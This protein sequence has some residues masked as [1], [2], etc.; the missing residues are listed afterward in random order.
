MDRETLLNQTYRSLTEQASGWAGTTSVLR[1]SLRGVLERAQQNIIASVDESTSGISQQFVE[2]L[3]NQLSDVSQGWVDDATG[4][5]CPVPDGTKFFSREGNTTNIIVEQKPQQRRIRFLDS[6]FL[7]SL[8]YIQFMTVFV[9]NGRSDVFSS[10]KVSCSKVPFSSMDQNVHVLPL[11]NIGYG[12]PWK[13]CT[14]RVDGMNTGG[15]GS[16]IDQVN[17]IIGSFW[18]SQFNTDLS[19]H[20]I[21]FIVNN[22]GIS[23][24]S[25]T[26]PVMCDGFLRWQEKCSQSPSFM[27][28]E[29]VYGLSGK[30]GR[31]VSSDMTSR[32]GRTAFKNRMKATITNNLNGLTHRALGELRAV[33]ITESNVEAIH[34]ASVNSE[35]RNQLRTGYGMLFN[36]MNTELSAQRSAFDG[37]TA[38]TNASLQR[39]ERTLETNRRSF[40]DE[41]RQWDSEKLRIQ[42]ELHRANEY[43]KAKIAE[44]EGV[45]LPPRPNLPTVLAAPVVTARRPRATAVPDRVEPAPQPQAAIPIAV[46]MN[47]SGRARLTMTQ[48]LERNPQVLTDESVGLS[49]E[50]FFARLQGLHHEGYQGG[51]NPL[52]VALNPSIRAQVLE[53]ARTHNDY[54]YEE[55]QG[56]R[57]Q[58]VQ[59]VAPSPAPVQRRTSN[60][61]D[62]GL[63]IILDAIA[64]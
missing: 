18:Q 10:L 23:R 49:R 43:L 30:V 55:D 37:E 6:H 25:M 31:L 12:D 56:D 28:Q 51:G 52:A 17:T 41:K 20:M 50:A 1:S 15:R 9:K 29:A 35:V 48:V 62:V 46:A 24:D 32:S 33:D 3:G 7:I 60:L 26:V 40:A 4:Q 54:V 21:D 2:Q 5:L 59:Q 45:S 64:G 34:L 58:V 27:L 13:V 63:D 53:A 22:F 61:Q 38:R 16:V 57:S 42:L 39:R 47:P 44:A 8:P 19:G 36:A 11:P 14:G